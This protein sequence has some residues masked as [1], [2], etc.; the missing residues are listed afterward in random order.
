[1]TTAIFRQISR[2]IETAEFGRQTSD[3]ALRI[4]RG[5]NLTRAEQ[6][7]LTSKLEERLKAILHR[8]A[9]TP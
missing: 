8:E 6:I 3:L 5:Q 7:M 2:Q 1:M 9:Q 4:E